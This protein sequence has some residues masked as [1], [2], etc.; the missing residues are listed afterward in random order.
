MTRTISLLISSL[1]VS[2]IS[3]GQQKEA[4]EKLVDEG[5]AYHD[6]GDYE[7]AVNKYNKALDL[8]KE[9]LLAL[10]EKAYSLLLWQKYDESIAC[11]RKAIEKH[12]GEKAL[13]VT[14]VT[15]G[16]ATDALKKTDESIK[17][18]NEGISQFPDAY[19]LYY[20]K[21]I[22]LSSVKKYDEAILSFQNS[23]SLKPSHGSSHNV[24]ARIL[25]MQDKRIP[26]LLAYCRF[27]VIEPQ[28]NRSKENLKSIQ[29]LMIANVEKTG[30]K[31]VTISVSSSML[32]DTT[33]D[34]KNK[35]NNFNATDMVLT[36][37]SALDFDKKNKNKSEVEKFMRKFETVCSSLK[38]TSKDNSGF[39]WS[40]YVPYFTEL[41][42]RNFIETFSYI[43]FAS[44]ED[45]DVSK[46]LKNHKAEIDKF[47]E[48]SKAYTWASK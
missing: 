10:T 7:G 3:F 33:A 32:N 16:N 39:Y 26:S 34:G 45:E 27:F 14:Y 6:K 21:G 43:V 44:S 22:T 23:V 40:Y 20:N 12:P 36:M 24:I 9:N 18:Y 35:E 5:I 29:D 38:E 13:A 41:A 11:C 47:Y 28:S 48:W 1:L 8:D 30:K 31:S 4:A 2:H 42:D 17:I 19:Q 37:A 25:N 46:W 15:Y